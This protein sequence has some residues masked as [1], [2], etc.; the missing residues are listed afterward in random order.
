MVN[1]L[2][3]AGFC[4]DKPFENRGSELNLDFPKAIPATR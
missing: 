2:V 3:R 1:E 4:E